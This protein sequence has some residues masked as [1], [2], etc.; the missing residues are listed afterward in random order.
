[1]SEFPVGTGKR[2]QWRDTISGLGRSAFP[3]NLKIPNG[4]T[5]NTPPVQAPVLPS[6]SSDIAPPVLTSV[7]SV[8]PSTIASTIMAAT[9]QA[10]QP[11]RSMPTLPAP[12]LWF[13]ALQ[14][15][16]EHEQLAIQSI[17][18]ARATKGPLSERIEELVSL[19]RTR[20]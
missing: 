19:T 16:S 5:L 4:G 3:R 15:L 13:D 12:D 17:Q 14:T 1:M 8:S 9:S 6:S 18:P 20:Q 7:Q 11:S 10:A 2:D